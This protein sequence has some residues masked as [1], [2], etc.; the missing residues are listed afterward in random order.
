MA[1]KLKVGIIGCNL[2]LRA[3]LPFWEL[4]RDRTEIVAVADWDP[5]MLRK[6]KEAY[7]DEHFDCLNTADEL[8]DRTDVQAVFIMVRDCFHE[9]Y[10]IRA[11]KSGKAVYLEKPMAITLEGCDRILKTAYETKSKLFIGHNMRYMPF[12]RKMKEIIDSGVI[13]RIHTVW[14]RHFVAY[15]S[16]YFRH[17]CADQKNCTGLLLQKG[18]H[19]ID[20]IQ[21]L[22]GAPAGRVAAMGQLSVYNQV[23]DLL[24][25][26]EKP[27]RKISFTNAS[28][29]P[30]GL[31]G[32]N[33]NMD[34]ED[35]N[36]IMMQLRN[37]VQACYMHCMY[38]P[39]SERNYTFIG[40]KGRLENVGDC[41]E[42]TEIHVWTQRGS[43]QKPDIVYHI[44]PESGGHGGADLKIVPAF[45]RF[46]MDNEIPD[47]S[48]VDARN[49][50][51]AGYLGHMSMRNGSMPVEVPDIPREWV[52]YFANGQKS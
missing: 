52:E 47:V 3:A 2:E 20:V 16:C 50:V 32:L 48:P 51:A 41:G 25:E 30:L 19:D 15:G 26:D 13:G 34:V 36:M 18:A 24:K 5:E 23:E 40:T 44:H 46:V 49:A 21:W 6:I 42:N 28:W 45:I 7:P 12:V 1:E 31:K 27:D 11:L 17:W 33:P 14:C 43:R 22:A 10:A 29:P 9:D 8:L 4:P 37:G 38:T 39:D 35:H